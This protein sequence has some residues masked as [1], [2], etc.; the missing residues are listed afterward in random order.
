MGVDKEAG[1]AG[2]NAKMAFLAPFVVVLALAVLATAL[3]T[4]GMS[5]HFSAREKAVTQAAV[6]EIARAHEGRLP[7]NL[8]CEPPMDLRTS[9]LCAQ[10]KAAD[11]ARDG[12]NWTIGAFIVGTVVNVLTLIFVGLTFRA[13]NR[14]AQMTV[15]AFTAGAPLVLIKIIESEANIVWLEDGRFLLQTLKIDI[16]W[17]NF[18]ARPALG[19]SF[20]NHLTYRTGRETPD[21]ESI[22]FLEDE[23]WSERATLTANEVRETCFD[24]SGG[25]SPQCDYE[26]DTV[27]TIEAIATY[28]DPA[29]LENVFS[30]RR[31]YDISFDPK[32]GGRYYLKN[33]RTVEREDLHQGNILPELYSS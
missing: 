5:G 29:D 16:V 17:E 1:K 14:Q 19:L 25:T 3:I 21:A 9:D 24:F 27:F 22:I 23:S 11:A 10:W 20:K 12:A 32:P 2:F 4:I 28:Y 26:A 7:E 13:T 30:I 33:P 31:S 15:K 18:G 6:V 8:P